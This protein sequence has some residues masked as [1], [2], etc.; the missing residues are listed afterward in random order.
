MGVAHAFADP[1]FRRKSCRNILQIDLRAFIVRDHV[2]SRHPERLCAVDDVHRARRRQIHHI[3][4]AHFRHCAVGHH[5]GGLV[6]K[7]KPDIVIKLDGKFKRIALTVE[8]RI[9]CRE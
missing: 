1:R 6:H 5:L 4:D 7:R 2:E 9:R 8:F 3:V